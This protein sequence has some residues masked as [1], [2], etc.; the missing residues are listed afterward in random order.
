MR[1][2][3]SRNYPHAGAQMAIGKGGA[4]HWAQLCPDTQG[5]FYQLLL[6]FPLIDTE[7]VAKPAF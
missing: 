2:L 6:L 1:E 4:L 3:G 5:C 7:P